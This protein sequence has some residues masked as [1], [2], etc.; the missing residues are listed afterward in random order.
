MGEHLA[1]LASHKKLSTV[2]S[3][4]CIFDGTDRQHV[5]PW[6]KVTR[7]SKLSIQRPQA[8]QSRAHMAWHVC[9][10]GLTGRNLSRDTI[11]QPES[12]GI[13]PDPSE[14]RPNRVGCYQRPLQEEASDWLGRSRRG[15]VP[16]QHERCYHTTYRPF[17]RIV[18]HLL[19]FFTRANERARGRGTGPFSSAGTGSPH[20]RLPE[21]NGP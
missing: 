7:V 10:I 6:L 9:R 17:G 13:E 19:A 14:E 5:R 2:A 12:L 1:S 4:S 16:T 18:D 3:T 11:V 15:A 8:E 20:S 21:S